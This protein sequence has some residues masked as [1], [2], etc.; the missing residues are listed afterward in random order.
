MR[1]DLGR[2]HD[3][4]V[5]YSYEQRRESGRLEIEAVADAGKPLMSHRDLVHLTLQF[6][7]LSFP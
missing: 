6:S 7:E 3:K 4:L 1:L 5:L 2:H